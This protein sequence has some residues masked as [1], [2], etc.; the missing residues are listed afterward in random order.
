M[1]KSRLIRQFEFCREIDKE[2]LV[3]RQTLLSDEKTRENDSEHAWH[4]AIMS[5]LLSEYSNAEIDLLK[6]VT[7]ILIHDI[8]EIDAGD[9]YAYDEE[10]KK[11]QREREIRASERIF[12]ILPED[13]RDKFRALWDEFEEATTAEASFA[14]AMDNIQ[15]AMLNNATDGKK[16][17]E[18]NI[19][20]SQIL[21]RNKNTAQGSEILWDYSFDNFIMPN[22]KKGR[23]IDDREQE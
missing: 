5:I 16:W 6:V 9:T 1:D 22:V 12:G 14:R 21:E 7:M 17:A 15:P 3:K 11:T 8:V 10:S 20:L 4:M 23:I 19:R 18:N 2:K 13:Q